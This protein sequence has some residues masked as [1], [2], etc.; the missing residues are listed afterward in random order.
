MSVRNLDRLLEPASVV[1]VG[2]SDRVGSVGA[3]VWRNL[4]ASRFTGPIHA[5][6]PKHATLDGATCFSQPADLPSV[7]DL[8]LICTPPQTVPGL[9]EAFGRLGTR[10]AIVMSAGLSAA[11]KQAM[12]DAAR[13]YVLRVLGPNCIGVLTPR[14]GLNASFA[15]IDALVGD[16][17]F[18]SQSGALVTAVLDWAKA[19]RIG[20]STMISLGERADVDFGDLLDH[21]ASDAAT[22]SILL[23][24]ESIEAPRKFMSAARAAARNK[25]VIVVKAGRAGNGIKAAASHTGAM[26]GS[27]IVFDAAIRR[28]GMLRVD[29]LQDLFMAAET[30]ARFGTNRDVALTLMT[31][32]GGAGV[33]A[34]D[35]A[36]LA[37]VALSELSAGTRAKLDALLPP[38][39][40][41][42]NPIDIIGDAPVRRYT[43]TLQ[44]VLDDPE[45]GAVLFLH[46]PTAIVRSDD[47]ARAC[48]PIVRGAAGRVMACW[49]G[50]SAVAEARSIL[51]EAGAADYETPEE[52]VRAFAMLAT[53]RRNQALLLETPAASQNVLPM[54]AAARSIVD[55]AIAEKREMLDEADAKQLLRAYGIP[56]V[57]TVVVGPSAAAAARAATELGYPIALKI[58]SPDISHK[59]DTGGVSLDLRDEQSVREAAEQMLA[60]VGRA[61]PDA[62]LT[63]FT[64][65]QMAH[66]PLAQELIVG[67]SI[68][69]LFGPVLL[70][71]HGG[72]AVEVIADRAVALPPLNRVLAAELVSRTRVARLLAGYRDHPPAKLDAVY[73]VLIALSQMLVDLPELAELDI[74]PLLADHEGVIALDARLRLDP[75]KRAGAARFSIVPY[76]DELVESIDWNGESIVV[77]PIRPEDEPQHR[78]FVEHLH[79]SDLRL[80]FFYF[81]RE[82]PRSELARLTQIDYA[83]EMAFIAVRRGAD[84]KEET[85]GVVRAVADPDNVEAEFAIVVRSDLKGRGLGRLLLAKMLAFLV[86]Q[87]TQRVV[88]YVMRENSAMRDLALHVGFVIDPAGSDVDALHVVLQLQRTVP[89]LD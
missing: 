30:L 29:T 17:A 45:A 46:A 82:L 28:A 53:Y 86:R 38:T 4:R 18:V 65:Q 79:P 5:L 37:G 60:R 74:N 3:T 55:K 61:L 42:G 39:W 12:L 81:R 49:L 9:I 43:E 26:A 67:A 48:A 1:V 56:V 84:G 27:D 77:R 6:N 75:Q 40:S 70:F 72:T 34:A 78:T 8:A 21:L 58:L 62:R 50:D 71:G 25:P 69:P 47:I 36:A 13:P 88:G 64:V 22:R 32:G 33:L 54:V 63:G 83:R 15:H 2:A 52:A 73:D 44:A 10:A 59:S 68:D 80:R 89:A 11:H 16:I 14:L 23:Y 7:P 31:N 85:L 51:A 24:I 35:A 87:G 41:H 57:E 76:P 20:F 66:R 19:R